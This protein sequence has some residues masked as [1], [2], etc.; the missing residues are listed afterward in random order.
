[1][2][3]VSFVILNY[4]KKSC[5]C[6]L[7]FQH[8][9]IVDWQCYNDH[10]IVK[11]ISLTSLLYVAPVALI[12]KTIPGSYLKIKSLQYQTQYTHDITMTS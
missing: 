4:H 8:S 10:A 11:K 9:V 5:L 1:M 7:Y 3:M 12:G 6:S 2:H